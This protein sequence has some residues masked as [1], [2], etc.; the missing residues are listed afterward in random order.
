MDLLTYSH[1]GTSWDNMNSGIE[2]LLYDATGY[3]YATY[4]Y[5]LAS[6]YQGNN[7]A[8]APNNDTKV[9]YGEPTPN[10][11]IGVTLHPNS[12]FS[13]ID[14]ARCTSVKFALYTNVAGANGDHFD[15]LYD[16]FGFTGSRLGYNETRTIYDDK[17]RLVTDIDENGHSTTYAMD[18]L[19]RTISS[20][21]SLVPVATQFTDNFETTGVWQISS[22]RS[23][24]VGQYSTTEAYSPTHSLEESFS[25]ALPNG[26]D[27]GSITASDTISGGSISTINLEMYVSQYSHDGSQWDQLSSGIELQ[28][29][30]SNGVNYANCSYWLASWYQGTNSQTSSSP[31]V[32][33]IY[34]KPTMS[35]WIPVTLNPS[36]DFSLNWADCATIK[37]VFFIN[38]AGANDDVFNVYY[39]NLAVHYTTTNARTTM[40]YNAVGDLL[41]VT[42]ADGSK[43]QM[44]Y[45]TM[46]RET[47]ITYPDSTQESWTYDGAGKV[48]TD[49]E[50][51]GT[52]L[53]S[54][55]NTIGEVTCLKSGS[56]TVCTTYD[57]DGNCAHDEQ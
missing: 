16:N 13:G 27:Y 25:G 2:M 55:Y 46:N 3:N 9:I 24:I 6:W 48:L 51:N 45:D 10:T 57:A 42:D 34:G 15:M 12:D 54:L 23:W 50:A 52:V 22:S 56:S 41:T 39:D 26:Q 17:D 53:S 33:V 19:G 7:I 44:N 47:S 21:E 38:V 36:K 8:T 31:Y 32:K 1:D 30:N 37:V 4:T 5:Y 14:W 11:W 40:T 49:T 18:Y 43:T 28:L 20:T 35:T 29:Y